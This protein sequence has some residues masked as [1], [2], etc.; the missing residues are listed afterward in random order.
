MNKSYWIHFF[1]V[2]LILV[3]TIICLTT[4]K[5]G[6]NETLISYV[7][8]AVGQASILLAIIT[9]FYSFFSNQTISN[10]LSGITNSADKI[11]IGS[12]KLSET[13]EALI[14]KLDEVTGLV[15]S[16]DQKVDNSYT[17]ITSIRADLIAN[18]AGL[19][20]K[21]NTNTSDKENIFSEEYIIN[22]LSALSF[23][24]LALIYILSNYKAIKKIFDP[25]DF[26]KITGISTRQYLYG[27]LVTFGA[28]GII[29]YQLQNN[30]WNVNDINKLVQK[31][32]K[33]ALDK[34]CESLKAKT[35]EL[36]QINYWPEKK[37]EVENYANLK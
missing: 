16:V 3:G 37:K 9:I 8:F 35:K 1:Y 32:V 34:S 27:G 18:S 10:N 28:M 33:N 26:E 19:T 21:S 2:V 30:S 29:S 14:I 17:T 11:T 24:L 31:H 20:V 15:H 22:F 7:S 6:G 13:A 12:T 23:N 5:Y 36:A 4:V 25:D